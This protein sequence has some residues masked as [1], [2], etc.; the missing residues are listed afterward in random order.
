[1]KRGENKSE[2]EERNA[3]P[4]MLRGGVRS[5]PNQKKNDE[6]EKTHT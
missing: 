1:M 4:Q 2:R 5:S 6:K 3:S